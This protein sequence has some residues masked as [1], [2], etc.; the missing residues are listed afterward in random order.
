MFPVGQGSSKLF[1][2]IGVT[3]K[4]RRGACLALSTA[5]LNSP[6]RRLVAIALRQTLAPPTIGAI[7]DRIRRFIH[8]ILSVNR[9]CTEIPFLCAMAVT[10]PAK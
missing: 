4:V 8:L 2:T 6:A 3:N 9:R 10:A 7:S 1:A 5:T